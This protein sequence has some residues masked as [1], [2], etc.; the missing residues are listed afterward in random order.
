MRMPKHVALALAGVVTVVLAFTGAAQAGVLQAAVDPAT[1]V[2]GD[3]STVCTVPH[4]QV[5]T[6]ETVTQP[7][8]TVTQPPVTETV[9]VTATPTT[10]PTTTPPPS[11][12]LVN[13]GMS[14]QVADWDTR[15]AQVGRCGIESR[16]I[17]ADLTSSG[18]SN[19]APIQRA[20][21]DGM[22]PVVSYKVP[23]V[24]TLNSNGYDAWLNNLNAYLGG[25]NVPV[26][27]TFW[28]EP[29]GDLTPAEFRAG[30]QQFLDHLTDPDIRVGPILNGWLLD[31]RVAD[32]ASYTSPAL[33]AAWDFAGV[34]TYQPADGNNVEYGGR[35]VPLLRDWL[36]SQGFPNEPIVVG[37][38]N[39][40]TAESLRLGG[41]AILDPANKVSIAMLW[42]SHVTGG[43]G[44]PLA[45]GTD[46]MAAFKATKADS[47]VLHETG[48]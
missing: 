10:T 25:L 29:H 6:T 45:P 21:A 20:V 1:C 43:L 42:N 9:T 33:L 40:F 48:C 19:T 16:R 13:I 31:R 8:V 17:F 2:R 24:A 32:Y 34:D 18:S 35:A 12:P 46:R 5:T 3:T 7:P 26:Y 14:A 38:Y 44:E 37:E 22:V 4:E 36:D 15:L 41:V 11:A 28:H 30:S 39:G 27:A 47:R 23:N